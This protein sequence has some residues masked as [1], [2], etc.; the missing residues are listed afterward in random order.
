MCVCPKVVVESRV[1]QWAMLQNAGLYYHVKAASRPRGM[2]GELPIYLFRTLDDHL[3]CSLSR[4]LAYLV[5]FV[6]TQ[7]YCLCAMLYMSVSRRLSIVLA[8][9]L[10]QPLFF[11]RP[12]RPGPWLLLRRLVLLRP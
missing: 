11:G 7:S 6:M 1:A 2:S 10:A 12:L 3:P 9:H 4:G 5:P 8:H